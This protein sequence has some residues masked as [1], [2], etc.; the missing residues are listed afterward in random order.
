VWEGGGHQTDST[1]PWATFQSPLDPTMVRVILL[2]KQKSG[3][4]PITNFPRN[5]ICFNE[6][7]IGS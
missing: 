4:T 7:S 1:Q 2:R 3:K 6:D 5:I